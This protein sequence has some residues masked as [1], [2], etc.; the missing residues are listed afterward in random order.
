MKED[1]NKIN[2][3]QQY[4][5]G[6]E[7]V[8]IIIPYYYG[9]I[10]SNNNPQIPTTHATI[11]QTWPTRARIIMKTGTKWIGTNILLLDVV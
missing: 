11:E 8:A 1:I 5:T 10:P 9:I 4:T 6:I 7:F 3:L 2:W